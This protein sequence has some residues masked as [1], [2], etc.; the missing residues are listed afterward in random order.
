M[1]KETS[2]KHQ[3][4]VCSKCLLPHDV[5]RVLCRSVC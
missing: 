2:E 3:N 1:K 4:I 5:V